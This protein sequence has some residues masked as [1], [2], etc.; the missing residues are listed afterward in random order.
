MQGLL[1]CNAIETL[2]IEN[3]AKLM[4]KV[5]LHDLAKMSADARAELLRRAEDDLAP[6]IE[7]IVPIV[8]AVRLEGDGALVRFAKQF[9]GAEFE[10]STI[11][12]TD[13][14][15]AAAYDALDDEFIEVLRY[16]AD[17]IRRFH[18]KQ[19][20]EMMWWK[21]APALK[22]GNALRRLIPWRV[23]LRAARVRFP[24]SR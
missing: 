12:A 6:F 9:D 14:D 23:I 13:E 2:P 8:E 24:L 17:N 5:A 1:D 16:S 19:M 20:P 21:S 22:W 7:K 15:F 10:A 4:T 3:M 18:E 11:A